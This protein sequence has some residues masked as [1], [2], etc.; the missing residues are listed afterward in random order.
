MQ[1]PTKDQTTYNLY[2]FLIIAYLFTLQRQVGVFIDPSGILRCRGRLEHAELSEGSKYPILLP[3]NGRFTVLI[4]E[5]IHK[6]GLHSGVSQTLSQI[7]NRY[8][9][10]QAVL[11]CDLY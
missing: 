8:W 2:Q 9:I 10:L 1:Y 3:R 6:K 5:M 4:I 7:R 11:Q